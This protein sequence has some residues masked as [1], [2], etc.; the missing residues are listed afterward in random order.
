LY[1]LAAGGS[2]RRSTV[3]ST[4]QLPTRIVAANLTDHVGVEGLDAIVVAYSL[5]NTIRIV[6]QRPDGTF[7]TPLA[8]VTGESPSDIA[9]EDIDGDGLRDVVVSNQGSGDV[10]VFLN[11]PGHSFARTLHFRAGTGLFGLETVADAPGVGSLEQS[12]SLATGAFTGGRN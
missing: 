9:L 12:V 10:S 5:D 4:S 6:F 2:G 7:G 3:F 8:L 1:E 11:D